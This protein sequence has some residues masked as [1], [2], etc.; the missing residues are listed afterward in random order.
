MTPD[1]WNQ[2]VRALLL[3]RLGQELGADTPLTHA[4]RDL[5]AAIVG[6]L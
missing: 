6:I 1:R 3:V 2:W 5:V 4:L